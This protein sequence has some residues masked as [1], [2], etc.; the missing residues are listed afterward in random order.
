MRPRYGNLPFFVV[1]RETRRPG[2]VRFRNV[3]RDTAYEIVGVVDL[4]AWRGTS[5][6]GLEPLELEQKSID[7]LRALQLRFGVIT[8][9]I[10]ND[11]S[12]AE[13]AKILM[14]IPDGIT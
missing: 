12:T 2:A 9:R 11:L 10:A 14:V 13:I 5:H 7:L 4:A 3:N 8:W 1:A 6:E